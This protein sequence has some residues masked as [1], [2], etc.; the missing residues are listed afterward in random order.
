LE[1]VAGGPVAI[2]N[3]VLELRNH[4]RTWTAAHV[5][6][7]GTREHN[8]Y[9]SVVTKYGYG[10]QARAMQDLFL[11]GQ[12]KAAEA[13]VPDDLLEKI[14]LIG[15][16]S[17]VRDRIAAYREAGVTVLNV[18]PVGEAPLRAIERVRAML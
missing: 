9:N 1:I 18:V 5:G 16:A 14:T 2:G 17:Y 11:S 3:S 13:A 6:G 12:R 10:I 4:W 7:Y 8:F 15:P